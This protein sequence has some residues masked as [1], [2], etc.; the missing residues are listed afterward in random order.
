[1]AKLDDALLE[2]SGLVFQEIDE[3]ILQIYKVADNKASSLVKLP[4][5]HKINKSIRNKERINFV[6]CGKS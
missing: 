4:E 3:V 1:M 5:K 2:A 6:F